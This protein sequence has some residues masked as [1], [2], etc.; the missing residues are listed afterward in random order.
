MITVYFRVHKQDAQLHPRLEFRTKLIAN[1]DQNILDDLDI[2]YGR[3]TASVWALTKALS[4]SKC[5]K[6]I[7]SHSAGGVM[8]LRY[9][10][11]QIGAKALKQL[12][13]YVWGHDT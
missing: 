11:G 9:L 6:C 3:K 12:M 2:V 5:N 8:K 10:M 1:G 13:G 7:M 4:D